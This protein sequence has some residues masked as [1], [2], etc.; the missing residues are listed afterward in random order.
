MRLL[1]DTHLLLWAIA[2]PERLSAE[3]RAIVRD[4]GN[5]VFFSAASIW[6]IAI[7]KSLARL[8][9]DFDP[10]QVATA[11]LETGFAELPVHWQ[12]ASIVA[13]LPPHHRDPF[14]RLIVAQAITGPLRLFTADRMLSRYS[15]LVQLV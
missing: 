9:F 14:D 6:E 3:V 11:A 12:A 1:L 2:H 4:P 5:E 13:T 8:D 10:E 7:K 15:E